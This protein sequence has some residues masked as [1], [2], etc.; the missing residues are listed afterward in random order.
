MAEMQSAPGKVFGILPVCYVLY[1]VFKSQWLIL[2]P[3]SMIRLE[4]LVYLN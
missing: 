2:F 1:K 4:L 3:G